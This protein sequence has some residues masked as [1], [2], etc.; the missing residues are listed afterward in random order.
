MD[1]W[2][3]SATCL[4]TVASVDATRIRPYC[5]ASKLN[6]MCISSSKHC[7]ER[8]KEHLYVYRKA[9]LDKIFA[10]MESFW[11]AAFYFNGY[12]RNPIDIGRLAEREKLKEYP[13]IK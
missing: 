4:R 10:D 5:I 3:R 7:R 1:P 11:W 2:R 13:I 12:L 8:L 6:T 9:D